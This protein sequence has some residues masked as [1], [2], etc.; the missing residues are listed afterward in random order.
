MKTLAKPLYRRHARGRN[1][2]SPLFHSTPG[3]R[4]PEP[5][6]EVLFHPAADHTANLAHPCKRF[7]ANVYQTSQW[8]ERQRLEG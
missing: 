6:H 1:S 2:W 4:E 5:K 8:V 3:C 7:K